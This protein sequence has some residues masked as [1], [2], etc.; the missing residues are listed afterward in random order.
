MLLSPLWFIH[1]SPQPSQKMVEQETANSVGGH[2]NFFW[3]G[4][5]GLVV[6]FWLTG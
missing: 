3:E 1:L 2:D 5:G 6:L 4:A